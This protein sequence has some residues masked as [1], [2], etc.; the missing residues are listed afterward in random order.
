MKNI[1]PTK[2]Q[3]AMRNDIIELLRKYKHLRAD[4]ILAIVSNMVGQIIALQDQ[5]KM[6]PEMA[7]KLVVANIQAGNETAIRN[8][9][10][11]TLGRA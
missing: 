1:T 7:M 9:F 3:L 10:S 5:R 4:E 6:T 2:D 8:S 11:T